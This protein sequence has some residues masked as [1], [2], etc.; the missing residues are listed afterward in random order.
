M[1]SFSISL[2]IDVVNDTNWDKVYGYMKKRASYENAV[3]AIYLYGCHGFS[4]T[5]GS[6]P[7]EIG[8]DSRDQYGG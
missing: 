1:K 8:L 6:V 4:R 3:L 5:N 7:V 2:G